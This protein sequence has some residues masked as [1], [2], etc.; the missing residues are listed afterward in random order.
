MLVKQEKALKR[1]RTFA[2]YFL[3]GTLCTLP[4]IIFGAI[5][6][7]IT[8]YDIPIPTIANSYFLTLLCVFAALFPGGL[9]F[10]LILKAY[11]RLKRRKLYEKDDSV[12]SVHVVWYSGFTKLLKYCFF[13]LVYGYCLFGPIWLL[14]YLEKYKIVDLS[15]LSIY[16]SDLALIS[17]PVL[18]II[19]IIILLVNWILKKQKYKKLRSSI[20]SKLS[21]SEKVEFNTI[22]EETNSIVAPIPV[23]EMSLQR[24][25]ESGELEMVQ[26]P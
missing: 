21:V 7:C 18:Y 14:G 9:I 26:V 2:K 25:T 5:I 10:C 4:I 12:I 22:I 23:I 24:N 6:I 19:L 17:M 16:W 20:I 3:F 15:W 1:L 8:D 13:I 11:N